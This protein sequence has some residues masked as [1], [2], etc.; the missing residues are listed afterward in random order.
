[1]GLGHSEDRLLH[2]AGKVRL[3]RAG[4]PPGI[5]KNVARKGNRKVERLSMP[6][7]QRQGTD[8]KKAAGETRIQAPA[9]DIL[10]KKTQR[11]KET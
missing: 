8:H 1:M 5:Q 11:G 7:N 9:V 2:L 3:A 6:G 4:A 10:K